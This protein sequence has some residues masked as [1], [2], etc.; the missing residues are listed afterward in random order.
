MIKIGTSGFSFQDWR[1][2]VYPKDLQPR[3]ALNYYEEKL[4]FDCVEINSTYYTL[5]STKSFEGMEK[6]T[7]HGF[8][9]VVKAYKGIT[10]DPFDTRFK[11]EKPTI[12]KAFQLI[13]IFKKKL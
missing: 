1:G 13:G 5:V 11:T 3:D 4:G 12:K 2:P 7:G 10:H 9:F 6:K 8:E